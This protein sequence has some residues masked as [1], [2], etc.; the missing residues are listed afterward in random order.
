MYTKEHLTRKRKGKRKKR[1]KKIVKTKNMKVIMGGYL[2]VLD[3]K[4]K[5]LLSLLS[6]RGL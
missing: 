3:I 4:E 1:N 2:V 6:S 5:S